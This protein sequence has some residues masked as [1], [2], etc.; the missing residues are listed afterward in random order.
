MPLRKC[1]RH[2]L[3]TLGWVHTHPRHRCFLS[4]IGLHN[5]YGYQRLLHESIAIVMAPKAIPSMRTFTL[6]KTGMSVIEVSSVL[7]L[8]ISYVHHTKSCFR[9]AIRDYS[10]DIS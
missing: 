7:A 5:H 10:M 9:T 4:S 6:T 2:N 8:D 1:D 3:M